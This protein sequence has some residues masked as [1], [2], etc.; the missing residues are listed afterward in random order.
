MSLCGL[1]LSLRSHRGQLESPQGLSN[2]PMSTKMYLHQSPGQST[3]S[4]SDEDEDDLD[5]SIFSPEPA[6]PTKWA[7]GAERVAKTDS[8]NP[9]DATVHDSPSSRLPPEV[10][11]HIFKQLS[12][13]RDLLPCLRVSRNWCACSVELLWHKP[14]FHKPSSLFQMVSILSRKP[15]DQTFTYPRFVRRLNFLSLGQDLSSQL[16]VR[17]A[18]CT[19]LERLTLMNCGAI[20]DDALVAALPAWPNLVA[21]DLTNVQD[22]TD[23]AIITLA[24]TARRLQGL[25]LG[26][27]KLVTDE[28]IIAVAQNSPQ[29]RRIKLG[30][31]E[32]ITD[33]AVTALAV[34][35]PL[36]LEVDLNNCE[37]ITDASV[38]DLW[39]HSVHMREFRLA[40]CR[41]LTDNGFPAP[42]RPPPTGPDPFP[43]STQVPSPEWPPLELPRPFEHLRILDLTSCSNITDSAIEGIVSNARKIRNL[44]LAKCHLLTDAAL[45]SICKL[46]KN[47]H[48]LHLGHASS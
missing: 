34:N 25:N 46:G 48:Y 33:R 45:E 11:I 43:T 23:R 6:S 41:N 18:A 35:C 19:R 31:L 2:S 40:N 8:A 4:L 27:C 47:L 3:T 36:L 13:P 29:L 38:R 9:A 16:F 20:T 44:V 12:S 15:Q 26:S 30:G 10:L 5:K 39:T 32:L 21:L 37:G 22:A 24:N 42:P 14:H 28:G 17:L 7:H 1:K